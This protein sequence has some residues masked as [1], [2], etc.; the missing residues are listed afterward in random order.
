[1]E[2]ASGLAGR[3]HPTQRPVRGR[4]R[5]DCHRP[6]SRLASGCRHA[7]PRD[8]IG[9]TYAGHC[10]GRGARSPPSR[11]TWRTCPTVPVRPA[12]HSCADDIDFS[13]HPT[14]ND[15]ALYCR[16]VPFDIAGAGN[17]TTPRPDRG[18]GPLERLRLARRAQPAGLLDSS[19]SRLPG[20]HRPP[21]GGRADRPEGV[22]AVESSVPL[23]ALPHYQ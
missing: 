10:S 7:H 21:R 4:P 18:D 6:P 2:R 20:D 22:A 3:T 11:A 1:M 17:V 13:V 23:A 5:T 19:M 9:A 12:V 16:Y 15:V 8:G 14:R